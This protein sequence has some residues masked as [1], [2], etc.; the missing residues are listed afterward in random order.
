MP[1][2]RG[3]GPPHWVKPAYSPLAGSQWKHS[4]VGF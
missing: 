4:E 1:V 2:G 3:V